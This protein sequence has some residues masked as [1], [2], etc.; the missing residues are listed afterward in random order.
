MLSLCLRAA[1]VI[2]SFVGLC[3]GI[4]VRFRLNPYIAP[5]VAAGGIITVLMLAGM[6][7]ALK[8]AT[9]ALYAAGLL[10][11]IYIC[12][13]KRI[14][15]RWKILIAC[16]IFLAFLIWYYHDCYL[17]HI[18]DFTHWGIVA[19]FLLRHDRFPVG[20]DNVTWHQSYPLG[21][22]CYLYYAAKL[23]GNADSILLAAQDFL[24]GLLFL[25][26]LSLIRKENKMLYPIAGL[27]FFG[28]FSYALRDRNLQVDMIITAFSTSAAA[29]IAY[30]RRDLRRALLAALPAMVAAAYIKNSGLFFALCTA[31]LLAHVAGR[32]GMPRAKRIL[33][34]LGAFGVPLLAYLLWSLRLRLNFATMGD[35]A[36]SLTTYLRNFRSKGAFDAA[37]I[38]AKMIRALFNVYYWPMLTTIILIFVC[39]ML[40][41]SVRKLPDRDARDYRKAML[42][43]IGI[44]AAWYVMLFFTYVFSMTAEGGELAG[45]ERYNADGIQY[46][47]GL[48]F[49]LM[50]L[51]VQRKGAFPDRLLRLG[52]GLSAGALAM[53]FALLVLPGEQ[54]FIDGFYLSVSRDAPVREVILSVREEYDL[55]NEGH[56]LFCFPTT[57]QRVTLNFVGVSRNIVYEFESVDNIMLAHNYEDPDRWWTGG[58]GFGTSADREEALGY[59][60]ENADQCDAI[61]VLLEDSDL[62]ALLDQ[63]LS[64]YDGNTPV[65]YANTQMV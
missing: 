28:I 7:N 3:M 33:L 21:S 47:T 25:P 55:P 20:A 37:K 61:V 8:P 26:V 63:F 57:R 12:A 58:D 38:A 1:L 41:Y 17:K 65:Y 54:C 34:G 48:L 14:A 5:S 49:I 44:Y 30:Y 16:G 43:A 53:V 42:R 24:V 51:A 6:M 59:L 45:H 56:Y 36:F 32:G 60:R 40:I 2:A 50:L 9:Y 19:R 39:A 22:A 23:L 52:G 35:H 4:R 11:L 31:A 62:K 27:L 10:C 13:V 18:D 46:I 64:E 29:G 15:P